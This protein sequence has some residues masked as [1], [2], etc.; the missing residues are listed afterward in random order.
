L[1]ALPLS[2]R[3]QFDNVRLL[4]GDN[5]FDEFPKT[6]ALAFWTT[7]ELIID[8]KQKLIVATSRSIESQLSNP[9][10]GFH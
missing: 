7:S 2:G 9:L 6:E 10:C 1:E 3:L 8:E 5:F 4:P